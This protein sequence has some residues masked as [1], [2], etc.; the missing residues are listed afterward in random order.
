MKIMK[1]K[2]D[3]PNKPLC[4][5]FFD[6][7][8]QNEM[9]GEFYWFHEELDGNGKIDRR[10]QREWKKRESSLCEIRKKCNENHNFSKMQ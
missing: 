4:V 10:A 9:F 7:I 6:S 2:I 3:S 5:F 8:S 1:M